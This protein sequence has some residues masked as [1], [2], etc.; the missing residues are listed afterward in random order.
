MSNGKI[1]GV[2][3]GALMGLVGLGFV[4]GGSG[5]LWANETQRGEDGFFTSSEYELSTAAYAVTTSDVSLGSR[6]GDWFP[7]GPLATVRL[8]AE[9]PDGSPI[10][11]GIGPEDDVDAFL[12]DVAHSQVTRVDED[13]VG[14]RNVTGETAPAIP[15]QEGFW[16]VATEGEGAQELTWDLERGRWVAVVMNAGGTPGVTVDV[17]AAARTDLLVPIAFGLMGIGVILG[18]IA[19]VLIVVSVRGQAAPGAPA[20]TTRRVGSV[21]PVHVEGQLDP[22]LSRWQ[23]LFKW[24]LVLPHF[25][26]LA[27]LWVAFVILTIVAWFAILFTGRYPRSIFDFNVGVMRWSWRVGYYSYSAL[28]TDQY[29][30]FT[31]ADTDYP[32]SFDVE[33]PERLSRGLVLVKTW[34]LAIPHYLIVGLFTSG[35]VWWTTE[36]GDSGNQ[37]A[38]AGAGLIGILVFIAAVVLLFTGRYPGGLFDLVMGLNRWVFRVAAYAA[39]MRDEY[40]PFRLDTGGSEPGAVPPASPEVPGD[41]GAIVT[42]REPSHS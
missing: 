2:I 20:G 12:A 6:P 39:L 27:F 31:L 25:I 33:Y 4:L 35:L 19:L 30:P 29:P 15:G 8:E 22:E 34:L 42:E 13:S 10:F 37:V 16:A 7:S 40:P 41:G 26:V 3:V 21:Y 32:A 24:L 17:T 38:E 11:I 23:W 14:Y 9:A 18:V 5:L 36:I 1:A 28:G